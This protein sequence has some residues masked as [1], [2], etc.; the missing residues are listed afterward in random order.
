MAGV[1][2][3]MV[4]TFWVP[5][6]SSTKRESRR[7]LGAP[8][9][10]PLSK[11][12]EA[13]CHTN[14]LPLPQ[15]HTRRGQNYHRR[16]SL[17]P[18]IPF[19]RSLLFPSTSAHSGEMSLIADTCCTSPKMDQNNGREN[20]REDGREINGRAPNRGRSAS[21]RGFFPQLFNRGEINEAEN[22]PFTDQLGALGKSEP[23]L[24][25]SILPPLPYSHPHS[26]PG[27]QES[28]YIVDT[29]TW[30]QNLEPKTYGSTDIA[31]PFP[32]SILRSK[33]RSS[34]S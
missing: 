4:P 32:V 3:R 27:K 25:S 12:L 33:L 18:T 5:S 19:R 28:D 15:I 11:F 6:F 10:W 22:D 34:N 26:R 31:F 30:I 24:S 21:R 7:R 23:S 29:E 8:N 1:D 13:R 9:L 20:G 2:V 14:T 17:C 16:A